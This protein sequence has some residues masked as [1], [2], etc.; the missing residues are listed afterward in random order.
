[1]TELTATDVPVAEHSD[2]SSR[3]GQFIEVN[4]AT[5]YYEDRERVHR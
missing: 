1:M 4:G 2:D 5:L 3:G